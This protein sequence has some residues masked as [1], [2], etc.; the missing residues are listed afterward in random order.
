MKQDDII[1][2]DIIDYGMDGEGVAKT[3]NEIIFIPYT[4]VGEKVRA[5]VNH[6]R[7]KTIVF[8]TLIEVIV[9]SPFRQKPICNRFGRCGGCDIMHIVYEEQLRIKKKALATI[10][11][12]NAKYQGE[13]EDVVPS[14]KIFD[15]RNKVQLPFGMVNG[16]VALGFF[17]NNSHKVVSITKCFLHGEWVEKLI[18]VFLDYANKYN[19]SVY[20]EERQSGLLRHLVARFIDEKI[21]IIVVIN[22]NELPKQKEL[23]A[24]IGKIFDDFSLYISVKKERDNV[25]MGKSIKPIKTKEFNINILGI[26]FEVNPYSFLQLNSYIRD[27]IYR[28]VIKEINKTEKNLVIDAYAGVGLMGAVLAKSGNK[29][30]NLEIVKEATEDGKIL[31]KNNNIE[32]KI[33]NINGDSAI[34]LPKV[35]EKYLSN[36]ETNNFAIILDPPRKGCSKE[37]IDSL[38]GINKPHKAFYISCNPAT[39]ARDLGLLTEYTILK[40]VPYDMFPNTK[41][42]ETLVYLEKH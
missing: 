4:V 11:S 20:N 13:I 39:L 2:V 42:L 12:K 19:L 16:K 38:N 37:V 21:T 40:I 30:I 17:R 32:D 31:A 35:I 7:K 29:V 9:E 22:G 14:D 27:C 6:V 36:E 18:S 24:E 3:E 1:I 8:A 23:L 5:K 26:D 33:E 34:L 41:H 10:L 25:V 28:E 15:Y